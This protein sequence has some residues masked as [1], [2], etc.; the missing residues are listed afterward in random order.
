MILKYQY[1]TPAAQPDPGFSQHGSVSKE[2][3]ITPESTCISKD[4][5]MERKRGETERDTT[6]TTLTKLQALVTTSFGGRCRKAVFGVWYD[7][8]VAELRSCVK[9]E[10][11]VLGSCP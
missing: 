7:T 1:R 2:K 8:S 3:Q 6:S 10:M 9:V 11:A 4:N 5:I